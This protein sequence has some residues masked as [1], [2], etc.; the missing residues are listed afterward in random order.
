M[1]VLYT[2]AVPQCTQQSE[3]SVLNKE[4]EEKEKKEK[5]TMDNN[6]IHHEA[7]K[8]ERYAKEKKLSMKRR[9]EQNDYHDRRI[10]MITMAIEGRQPL[11]GTIR[12]KSNI[13]EGE[14][15]PHVDLSPLGKKVK[16][17]WMK[18]PFFPPSSEAYQALHHARPHTWCPLRNGEDG[19]TLRRRRQ[20]IQNRHKESSPGIRCYFLGHATV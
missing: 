9:C 6:G 14:Q 11:L 13:T 4:K 10:Y 16:D 7:T 12:G 19:C 3:S 18:N 20:R 1:H 2:A 15:A 8:W 17:C 5:R